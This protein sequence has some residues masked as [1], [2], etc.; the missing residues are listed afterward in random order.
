M[1]S[2]FS[3]EPLEAKP[4]FRSFPDRYSLGNFGGMDLMNR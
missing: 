1:F 3:G 2:P 4:G